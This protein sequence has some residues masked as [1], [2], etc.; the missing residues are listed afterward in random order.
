MYDDTHVIKHDNRLPTVTGH[1]LHSTYSD[2][3]WSMTPAETQVSKFFSTSVPEKNCAAAAL[4]EAFQRGA[5]G[6]VIQPFLPCT[7]KLSSQVQ[8]IIYCIQ[9]TVYN[10]QYYI[11]YD[12]YTLQTTRHDS[13]IYYQQ[14]LGLRS[15]LSLL[16]T[17]TTALKGFRT[18]MRVALA[19]LSLP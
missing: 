7:F 5:A 2:T 1:G 13:S 14:R 18:K 16:K 15:V 6:C 19:R 9:C 4:Q 11:Q 3:L 8:I 12:S 10:T 17:T